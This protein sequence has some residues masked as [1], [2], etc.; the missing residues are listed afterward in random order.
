M[1]RP[2]PTGW[3]LLSRTPV[4]AAACRLAISPT[5]HFRLCVLGPPSHRSRKRRATWITERSQL[6]V[7]EPYTRVSYFPT[8]GQAGRGSA[9]PDTRAGS[10][11][12]ARTVRVAADHIDWDIV[13]EG[14]V[15]KVGVA[16]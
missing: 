11:T 16:P 7:L 1:T 3:N 5:V 2:P 6:H 9:S 8:Q 15:A 14:I 13:A 4:S 12:R 10:Y